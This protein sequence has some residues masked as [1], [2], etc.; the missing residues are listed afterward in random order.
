MDMS[1]SAPADQQDVRK[2]LGMNIHDPSGAKIGEVEDVYYHEGTQQ[3][4]WLLVGVG[5]FGSARLIPVVRVETTT[6]GLKVE[7]SKDE[8]KD[9]PAI[10]GD[11]VSQ[12]EEHELYAHY[13]LNYGIQVG[14]ASEPAAE[15]KP[16]I[17]TAGMASVD[18]SRARLREERL[19]ET[20]Q[21]EATRGAAAGSP[22]QP[23]G[24]RTPKRPSE[25]ALLSEVAPEENT[26][27]KP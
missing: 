20:R 12:A 27:P 10:K 11:V 14:D 5:W 22:G 8:V 13:G 18:V 16:G 3:P 4:E 9:S 19:A 1:R 23:V 25:C 24:D 2:W 17:A 26:D 21:E 6:E 15:R 7:Y